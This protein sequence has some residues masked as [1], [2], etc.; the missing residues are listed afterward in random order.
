MSGKCCSLCWRENLRKLIS[1][2]ALNDI[3]ENK[4]SAMIAAFEDKYI[5]ILRL[6]VM[7][8]LIDFECHRLTRPHI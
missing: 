3:V 7:Q 5:L 2:C 1:L 4:H 6:L 8:Y